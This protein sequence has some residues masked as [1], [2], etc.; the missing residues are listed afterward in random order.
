MLPCLVLS[1]VFCIIVIAGESHDSAKRYLK[2]M[3]AIES[4]NEWGKRNMARVKGRDTV[5]PSM[6]TYALVIGFFFE[7]LSQ[8]IPPT[9]DEMKAKIPRLR[10]LAKAN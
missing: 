6:Q 5:E 7:Y 9:S 3:Q 2:L 4:Q 1:V 10:A 8:I